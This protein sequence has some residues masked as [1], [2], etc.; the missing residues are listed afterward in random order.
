MK[1]SKVHSNN[2]NVNIIECFLFI[3]KLQ[4]C[5]WKKFQTTG[6]NIYIYIYINFGS[7]DQK[8]NIDVHQT[9]WL[10]TSP[11][12]M[13]CIYFCADCFNIF[14]TIFNDGK[15]LIDLRTAQVYWDAIFLVN[16]EVYLN[17]HHFCG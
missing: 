1:L 4:Q 3:D 2:R 13:A 7:Q 15:A 6:P 14:I 9:E 16:Q 12:P 10:F 17:F 8:T 11:G 5:A